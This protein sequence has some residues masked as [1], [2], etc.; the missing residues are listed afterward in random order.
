MISGQPRD[1]AL[2]EW[3]GRL[4][5]PA[6]PDAER[7][8][9]WVTTLSGQPWWAHDP[10]PD[11]VREE[12]FAAGALVM[13]WGGA[14]RYSIN[15][16]HPL[17][18]LLAPYSILQHSYHVYEV[19]RDLGGSEMEQA[20]AALHDVHEIAPPGDVLTPVTRGDTAA[21]AEL[22]R[23]SRMAA[24]CFRMKLGLPLDMPAIVKR[25]DG[26]LL[27]TERRD[28]SRWPEGRG[29]ERPTSV[30]P[31]PRHIVAW[32]P[33]RTEEAFY[34]L[35]RSFKTLL[36]DLRAKAAGGGQR[37]ADLIEATKAWI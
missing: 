18:G 25:A 12:D 6:R 13:R 31:L 34:A 22:K 37:S 19:V 4:S 14:M 15:A 7:I 11:D 30:E 36:E 10:H 1:L 2:L 5:K 17:A 9:D 29:R 20:Y 21:A 33:D 16:G 27:A 35:Y 8:G 24:I 26:I 3:F 23:M 28:L 32:S